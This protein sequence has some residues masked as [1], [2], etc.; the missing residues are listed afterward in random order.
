[1][2]CKIKIG[3]HI[4]TFIN[5]NNNVT[6]IWTWIGYLYWIKYCLLHL[7]KRV[8]SVHYRILEW[9]KSW[10]FANWE[11]SLYILVLP[12]C[13]DGP[14]K[15]IAWAQHVPFALIWSINLNMIIANYVTGQPA[16]CKALKLSAVGD[17]VF[18][19][20]NNFSDLTKCK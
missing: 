8:K 4:V 9:V 10:I 14:K 19:N 18:Q 2:F 5:D 16:A 12:Q 11:Q 1:M 15:S 20:A 3:R 13:N 6:M 17:T 7:C